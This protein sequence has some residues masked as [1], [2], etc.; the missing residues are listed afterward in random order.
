[1]SPEEIIGDLDES[2]SHPSQ[3]VAPTHTKHRLRPRS[4][5]R[6]KS[7]GYQALPIILDALN[8][9]FSVLKHGMVIIGSTL[10][11]PIEYW[12]VLGISTRFIIIFTSIPS[13]DTGADSPFAASSAS[14]CSYYASTSC[15]TASLDPRSYCP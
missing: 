3:T 15:P 6:V 7:Y 10:S 12:F 9:G 1:M 4:A 13:P 5:L 8:R 2:G 14:T 11:M